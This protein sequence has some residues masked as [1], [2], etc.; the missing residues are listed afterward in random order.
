MAAGVAAVIGLRRLGEG[1]LRWAL[2]DGVVAVTVLLITPHQH[3]D[4]L[5]L[6]AVL[7]AVGAAAVS[8]RPP[9][10]WFLLAA[11]VPPVLVNRWP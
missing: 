3:Y 11:M 10:R 7:P 5:L 2:V 1:R 4:A 6:L 9:L 8:A